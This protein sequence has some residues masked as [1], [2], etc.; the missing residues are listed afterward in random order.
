MEIQ[1]FF[2]GSAS[3]VETPSDYYDV[4][5]INVILGSNGSEIIDYSKEIAITLDDQGIMKEGNPIFE[6][7]SL[8][9]ERNYSKRF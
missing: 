6:I 7:E 4:V 1:S 5:E 8:P 2:K 3:Y 9:W